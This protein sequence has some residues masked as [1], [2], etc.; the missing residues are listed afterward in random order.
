MHMHTYGMV[1]TGGGGNKV[2][3][4][5]NGKLRFLSSIFNLCV[6]SSRA[7]ISFLPIEKCIRCCFHKELKKVLNF[8]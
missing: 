3:E 7:E 1:W 6:R 4:I 5:L 2:G 8:S